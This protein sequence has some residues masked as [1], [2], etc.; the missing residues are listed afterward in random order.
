[1]YKKILILL[2]SFGLIMTHLG[3]SSSSDV[4]SDNPEAAAVSEGE[5]G[6]EFSEEEEA[7][8]AA[9]EEDEYLAE[10]EEPLGDDLGDGSLDPE[11]EL[12][13]E[14]QSLAEE[15]GS[16]DALSDEPMDEMAA[17]EEAA[18]L[19]EPQ[20]PM[21]DTPQ[22]QATLDSGGE[23]GFAEEPMGEPM[24]EPVGEPVAEAVSEEGGV[25]PGMA[26]EDT[27]SMEMADSGEM[28]APMEKTWVPVKKM[29]DAP[30]NKNGVLVNAIYI[31]RS[32]DTA[33]SI[34]QKLFGR[35]DV[36]AIYKVN[37]TLR[38]GIKV[39]DKVYY[40][41]PNRPNDNSKLLTFYEDQGLAPEVYVA[42]SGDNIRSI[43][44]QMLGSDRSW[45]E[46]YATNPEVDTKGELSEGTQIRYWASTEVAQSAP[47]M[48]DPGMDAPPPPM[49]M[50]QNDL[51]PPP[52]MGGND[53]PPP[54]PSDMDSNDLPPPPPSDMA[55]NDLPPPPPAP[56]MG[57]E[58]MPPPP[59]PTMGS[60]DE[61]IAPPPPPPAMG[62]KK[63]NK[64]V[65]SADNQD[66]T[67]MMGIGGILAL[68]AVLLFIFI[69]KKKGRQEIDF[70]TATQTQI[71]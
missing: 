33:E 12:T 32:G 70:N 30:F 45:M 29:A 65:A 6:G 22:D 40:N 43:A 28:S 35:E 57:G 9:G 42:K 25:D 47:S 54:P 44:K 7:S 66:Q 48:S 49:D 50:A 4:D 23:T 59:P 60:V 38:R 56:D 10:E 53:L 39:G 2:L 61:G 1:M 19:E 71:D 24:A 41:S 31:A 62:N 67:M 26:M 15:G 14:G 37:T 58:D 52:D 55:Q 20:D 69:K 34:S 11:E 64:E 17:T 18:P 21:M 46:F 68:A 36:E 13:D 51:P 3:C 8:E 5:E 63:P 16:E 27:S